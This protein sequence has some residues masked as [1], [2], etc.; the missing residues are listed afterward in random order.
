MAARWFANLT[1]NARPDELP[2]L[3]QTSAALAE[4]LR[5]E[6]AP[7]RRI[8][9]V[10]LRDPALALR[11]LQR[12]NAV[13]RRHPSFQLR[14]LEEAAQM[15][16]TRT[17][18]RLAGEAA[19]ERSLGDRPRIQAYRQTAGRAVLSAL[20][21]LDWA[22]LDR[23][24][25]PAEIS[26]AALLHNLGERYLI[27][28]GD[29]RMQ[30]YLDM[31]GRCNAY[32][33][34][35]EYVTLG[36]S[37]ET[38]GYRLAGLWE[39]PLLIREAMRARNAQHPRTLCVMLATQIARYAC[40]GWPHPMQGQ[41]LRL[42]AGL[43]DLDVAALRA[44]INRVLDNFNVGVDTYALEPLPPLPLESGEAALPCEAL[45]CL[46][47]RADDY[48]RAEQDLEGISKGRQVC[49]D[50]TAIFRT[51]LRGLHR[52]LGLSRVVVALYDPERHAVRAEHLIGTDF[53]PGFNRF[54]LPMSEAGLFAGLV[55]NAGGVW[56]GDEPSAGL[57][58]PEMVRALTGAD[59]FFAC[60]LRLGG[61]PLGL[62]YADR[63]DASCALDARSFQGFLRLVRMAEASLE[64]LAEAAPGSEPEPGC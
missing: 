30:R 3:S 21:A 17:L 52:G 37:L 59:S 23:D 63:R 56:L 31:V 16:G 11:V 57:E 35:V 55:E 48:A 44:R 62:V 4:V 45:F 61:Q 15:L 36:E 29:A 39:L 1:T 40:A 49:E 46:A 19:S 2:L 9:G 26:L 43:L 34:E 14:S 64:R 20:L 5:D 13:P 28:H 60:S 12:A 32:P 22:E 38:I 24:R 50:R 41:D 47:P 7:L 54:V 8:T 6:L 51:M 25:F 27:A 10:V 42:V 18:A 33:H 53:E 58:M